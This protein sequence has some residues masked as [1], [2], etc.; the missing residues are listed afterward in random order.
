MAKR[1]VENINS[2]YIGAA[3]KL[4]SKTRKRKIVVYVEG[5]D[6]VMFW[7]AL[8]NGFETEEL[9]F[10]IMLPSRT[11]LQK[12]KKC[13]IMNTLG[14]GAGENMIVCVDADYDYLLQGATNISNVVCHN[15]YVFHTYA[16]AIEN[17]QCYAPSLHNVCVMATLN[18]H[19]IFDFEQFMKAW[20][21]I[22]FPIFIWSI[23]CYK[24]KCNAQFSMLDL[25]HAMEI[26][27]PNIQRPDHILSDVEKKV[28]SKV[29]W[30]QR[31]FPM[32]K[33]GYQ[34]LREEL[35]ELGLTPEDTYL[36]VRGHDLFEKVVTP[37]LL[38]VCTLL[39]REREREILHLANH[40]K[41]YMNE[42]AGYQHS[43]GKPEEMLRKHTDYHRAP[44]YKRVQNDIRSFL[45][46]MNE[47][48]P[49]EPDLKF[50]NREC[51]Q[52]P[53]HDL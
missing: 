40:E 21:R 51:N 34:A 4:N 11:S 22:V 19:V 42:L 31:T 17:F 25:C 5:Y 38:E 32:A 1:L 29:A 53:P 44:L 2:N 35:Q 7:R 9:C 45:E 6:D 50:P 10:E 39:R 8:L 48:R 15:P 12:G 26:H 3:G 23:W 46:H 30:L 36:Y 47:Q 16:Y 41:Q 52:Q 18:D 37:L 49:N 27:S 24:N 43:T 33:G 13:A 14:K 20:S 28:N